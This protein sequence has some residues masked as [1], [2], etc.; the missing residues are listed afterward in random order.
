[1]KWDPIGFADDADFPADEYDCLVAPIVGK[2]SDGATVQQLAT[3]LG[4]Q[5]SEHF[6]LQPSP[7]QDRQLATQLT[8]WWSTHTG[9]AN[10]ST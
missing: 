3:W 2:L 4:A 8:H 5:R 9:G 1:M 10:V 7:A 6:G